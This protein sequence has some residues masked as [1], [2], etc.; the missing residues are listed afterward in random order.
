METALY[1]GVLSG[2]SLTG[3]KF[4]YENPLASDGTHHRQDWYA[5]ACCPPNISRLLSM[6]GEYAYAL[7]DGELYINLFIS[8][9]VNGTLIETDYPRSGKIRVTPASEKPVHIRVPNWCEKHNLKKTENGYA[10]IDSHGGKPFEIEFEMPVRRVAAHPNVTQNAGRV[11][12]ARGPIVY[13]LEGCDNDGDIGNLSIKSDTAIEEEF[14]ESLGCVTLKIQVRKAAP[15]Q[16][17]L[18]GEPAKSESA[19]A[20]AIPYCLWDNREPGRMLVWIPTW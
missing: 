9:S 16:G 6:I 19:T 5:C 15:W 17:G 7:R 18:Y 11:A 12:L 3:T 1:N 10:V 20:K 14:D 13:C 2:I 4:F 8:G